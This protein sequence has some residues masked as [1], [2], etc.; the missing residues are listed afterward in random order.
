MADEKASNA[1]GATEL[2][3]LVRLLAEVED[4]AFRIDVLRGMEDALRGRKNVPVPPSWAVVSQK[5]RGGTNDELRQRCLR[6]SLIFR[7]PQAIAA[8]RHQMRDAKVPAV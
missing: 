4:D 3:P 1:P 8:L 7:E 6:L 5:L 2:E